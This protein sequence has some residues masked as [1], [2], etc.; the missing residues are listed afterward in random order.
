MPSYRATLVLNA[1]LALLLAGCAVEVQNRQPLAAHK[2]AVQP[3]GSVYTGWRGFEDQCARCHGV[4][5]NGGEG[6]DLALRMAE[7]GPRRFVD[8]VLRRY[9]WILP[10]EQARGDAAARETLVEAIVQRRQGALVMPAWQGE[11]QVEAHILDLYA[12]LAARADGSQ[13]PGRPAR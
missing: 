9:D 2:A 8:L 7:I 13:G 1:V 6:P 11:P 12:Y 3:Q 5:A 10:D 4:D